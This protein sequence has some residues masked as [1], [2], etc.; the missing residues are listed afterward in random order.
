MSRTSSSGRTA[1][2]TIRIDS[3]GKRILIIPVGIII[4]LS[5]FW[6]LKWGLANMAVLRTD[7]REITEFAASTAPDDPQTHFSAAVLLEK[8]FGP[9][10]VE[11]GLHEYERA[12][13][14]SPD[15]YLLWLALGQA[16]S[17]SGDTDGAERAFRRALELA[18][19]YARV[20]WALGN[21]LVRQDR[22]DE[23]FEHIRTAVAADPTFTD[24]AAITAWQIF[25]G[26]LGQVRGALRESPRLNAALSAILAKQGRFDEAL[27][28]WNDL[29]AA[30]RS[31]DLS[32]IGKLL[33]NLLTSAKRFRDLARVSTDLAGG[34]QT[35]A[36]GLLSNGGFEEGLKS[37]NAGLFEWQVGAGL[38][39]QIALTNGQKHS[40]SNSIVFIFNTTDSKDFRPVSQTVAVEPGRTYELEIFYRA[41]MKSEAQFKWEVADASSGKVLAQTE[42]GANR[43]DWAP[44]RA[45]FTVPSSTDG[46]IVRL[47]RENCGIVCPVSGNL[48]FDDATLKNTK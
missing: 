21:L 46:I 15:N 33:A 20:H 5:S 26:D 27:A 44:L 22:A 40:G 45:K 8:S 9:G 13:A 43:S 14:L 4:L 23:G 25:D 42:A 1:I 24:A 41:D 16:R 10:D 19:N 29:P 38:Q 35:F 28:I 31:R 36:L 2:N 37:Q 12:A 32:E 7:N 30:D 34:G 17:R 47:V 6:P 48:W 3:T 18:P 39:P 11:K